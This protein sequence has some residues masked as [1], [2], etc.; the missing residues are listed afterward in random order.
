MPINSGINFA[1]N[2]PCTNDLPLEYFNKALSNIINMDNPEILSSVTPNK[3]K[4]ASWL[5]KKYETEVLEN[6]LYMTNGNINSIQLLMDVFMESGDEIIVEGPICENLKNIF[7]QYGL[8]INY[9]PLEDDG[10]NIKILE[11]KIKYIE[12]LENKEYDKKKTKKT[13]ININYDFP[14]P[15]GLDYGLS[16]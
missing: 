13:K 7:E 9:V 2:Q 4:L 14:D 3:T 11:E 15:Y 10:I 6:E 5:S 1:L 16:L 12:E 8:N